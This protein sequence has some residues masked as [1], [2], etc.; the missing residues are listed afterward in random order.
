MGL[1]VFVPFVWEFC[2]FFFCL[3]TPYGVQPNI[4]RPVYG[5]SDHNLCCEF[6]S[7]VY[8]RAE[9]CKLCLPYLVFLLSPS[10]YDHED[11]VAKRKCEKLRADAENEQRAPP[12]IWGTLRSKHLIIDSPAHSLSKQWISIHVHAFS[13]ISTMYGFPQMPSSSLQSFSSGSLGY[14]WILIQIHGRLT[15]MEIHLGNCGNQGKLGLGFL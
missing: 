1:V 12:W 15:S 5:P 6:S 14:S 10:C 7:A 9:D 4:P 2:K 8:M 11:T 3:S 13:K